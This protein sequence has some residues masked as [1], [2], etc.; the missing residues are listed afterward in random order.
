MEIFLK[1]AA[2][3]L[4]AV[5]LILVLSKQGKDMSVLLVI[6]ACILVISGA[7]SFLQPIK[8]LIIKLQQ[9]GQWESETLSIVLKAVGIGLIS[10]ITCLICTDA[11]NA[12][13]GKT[14]QF[15]ASIVI[16]WLSIPLINDLLALLDRI[17]G[18]I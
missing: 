16:L 14:L 5:I 2:S 18:A 6:A 9:V 4:I 7:V 15:M 1:A 3:T 13:L 17:L 12:A 8:D 10:E 11:G